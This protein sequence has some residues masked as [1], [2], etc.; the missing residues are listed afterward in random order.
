MLLY[1]AYLQMVEQIR[2]VLPLPR[3]NR[4]YLPNPQH[5]GVADAFGFVFLETD[6]IG[7]FYISL[8]ESLDHL[9]QQFPQPEQVDLPLDDLLNKLTADDLGE[10]A[11]G[12]G[13]F[14]A[15]SQYVMRLADYHP[16]QQPPHAADQR[17]HVL[18]RAVGKVDCFRPVVDRLVAEGCQ[19]LV[20]E[21]IPERITPHALV[22]A[23]TNPDDLSVCIEVLCTTLINDTLD[24]VL[25]ACG[26]VSHF[27]LI[28][29]SAGGLPDVVFSR[30]VQE[31][32]ATYYPDR[33][34]LVDL[35]S[36]HA[37]LSAAGRKYRIKDADYPGLTELLRRAVATSQ[38]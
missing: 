13:A 17:L 22:T 16:P 4:L 2:E 23:T 6:D 26:H 35:L 5:N 15:L 7:A 14:N 21:H 11:I 24:N 20:L 32:G 34:H 19:A 29:P 38:T 25:A 37:A 10:R 9:W 18:Q 30:G 31:I 36:Q 3:V 28:G 33:T 1:D 8:G 27:S 12:L